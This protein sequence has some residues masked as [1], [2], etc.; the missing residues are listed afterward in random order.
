M[1]ELRAC[2]SH[3]A[4]VG[5]SGALLLAMLSCRSARPLRMWVNDLPDEDVRQQ[6]HYG[7]A[8]AG[9]RT[10]NSI[11]KQLCS[12]AQ[13]GLDCRICDNPY[14]D[15]LTHL[16]QTVADWARVSP[17]GARLGYLDPMKYSVKKNAFNQTCSDDH[18]QWLRIIDDKIDCPVMSVHFTGNPR[19]PEALSHELHSMF[20]DGVGRKF[21]VL[22]FRHGNYAAVV[23]VKSGT[24]S[25][26]D[27]I[28]RLENGVEESW[29][30]WF[31]AVESGFAPSSLFG[32]KR[33]KLFG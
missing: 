22:E 8:M 4:S 24:H 10:L 16:K 23:H 31:K 6:N 11:L 12:N 7:N 1:R 5:P 19:G 3:D 30:A 26:R 25:Q 28:D 20:M 15:S 9:L 27:L 2:V 14:P 29:K 13:C 32:T 33:K 21:E 17:P 18:K